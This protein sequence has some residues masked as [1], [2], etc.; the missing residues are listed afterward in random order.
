[1]SAASHS[2]WRLTPIAPDGLPEPLLSST[3]VAHGPASAARAWT[4]AVPGVRVAVAPDAWAAP[5]AVVGPDS[6]PSGLPP[7]AVAVSPIGGQRQ[8]DGPARQTLTTEAVR[9]ARRHLDLG[10]PT[11]WWCR[12]LLADTITL[13]AAAAAPLAVIRPGDPDLS[14]AYLAGA[15]LATAAIAA[16]AAVVGRRRSRRIEALAHELLATPAHRRRLA[17]VHACARLIRRA[18]RRVH[19]LDLRKASPLALPEV[20]PAR[21]R[22]WL[23]GEGSIAWP[24]HDTPLPLKRLADHGHRLW[25][26]PGQVSEPGHQQSRGRPLEPEGPAA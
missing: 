6:A 26:L 11:G 17:E 22:V 19:W 7:A 24:R 12:R 25:L 4:G 14:T 8:A 18:R 16:L 3:V 10:F 5:V 21:A 23:A 15:G 1:M 9:C 2:S 20:D 13:L